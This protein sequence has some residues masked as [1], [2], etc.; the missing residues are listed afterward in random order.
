MLKHTISLTEAQSNFTRIADQLEERPDVITVTLN[1]EPALVIL[2]IDTYRSLFEIIEELQEE[3]NNRSE[4]L[5]CNKDE[6][7]TYIHQDKHK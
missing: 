7:Q 4:A 3:I 5:A 6:P 1:E 2:P